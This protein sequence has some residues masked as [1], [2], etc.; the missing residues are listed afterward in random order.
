MKWLE[1]AY[2]MHVTILLGIRFLMAHPYAQQGHLLMGHQ[3]LSRYNRIELVM[4]QQLVTFE[5][6]H[7][8]YRSTSYCSGFQHIA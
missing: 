4:Q 7:G 2:I 6:E 8:L 5:I 1:L 3:D